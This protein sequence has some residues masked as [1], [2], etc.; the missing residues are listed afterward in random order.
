MAPVVPPQPPG[1]YREH[2]A[3][4][5]MCGTL[6]DLSRFD[7]APYALAFYVVDIGGEV[8]P[9]KT[10]VTPS[11]RVIDHSGNRRGSIT[12]EGFWDP[13]LAAA[14]EAQVADLA[15]RIAEM[16]ERAELAEIGT[17]R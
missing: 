13:R 7:R 3:D 6:V 8:R 14:I 16:A 10:R 15:A 4:C 1:S 17:E 5:P 11:G 2:K 12:V 9:G